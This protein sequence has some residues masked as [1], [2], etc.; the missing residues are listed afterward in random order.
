MNRLKIARNIAS[1]DLLILIVGIMLDTAMKLGIASTV[2]VICMFIG[3]VAYIFGG[4]KTAVKMSVKI[5]KWGWV[6]IPFPFD[7]I[8]LPLTFALAI[9]LFLF[10]PYVPI[11]KAYKESEIG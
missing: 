11:N 7:L 6:V 1:V 3:I 8:T 9:L 5:M 4:I 2:L 10:V